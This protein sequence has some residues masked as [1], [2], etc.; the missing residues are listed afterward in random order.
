M[1]SVKVLFIDSADYGN[2]GITNTGDD[3]SIPPIYINTFQELD[4][5]DYSYYPDL[6]KIYVMVVFLH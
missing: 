1:K 3:N 4:P 2:C 6:I 5:T